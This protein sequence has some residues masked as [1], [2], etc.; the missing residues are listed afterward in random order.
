MTAIGH[1]NRFFKL[2]QDMGFEIKTQAFPDHHVWRVDDF[3]GGSDLIVMTG[4][5]AVKCGDFATSRMWYCDVEVVFNRDFE[6][7]C[8]RALQ[9]HMPSVCRRPPKAPASP[10]NCQPLHE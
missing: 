9:A 5:D 4:K 10:H 6:R 8:Q 2:L 7:A 3:P 1:A